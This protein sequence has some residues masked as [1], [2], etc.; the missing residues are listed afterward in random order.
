MNAKKPYTDP[1]KSAAKIIASWYVI[2][3]SQKAPPW[4]RGLG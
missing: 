2:P 3:L 1:G 4:I